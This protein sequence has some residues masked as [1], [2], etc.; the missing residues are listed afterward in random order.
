MG[1][2]VEAE[3]KEAERFVNGLRQILTVTKP[4]LDAN[5]KNF[6]TQQT[7]KRKKRERQVKASSSTQTV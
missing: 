5:I 7:R 1:D 2:R 4:E 3:S 6:K